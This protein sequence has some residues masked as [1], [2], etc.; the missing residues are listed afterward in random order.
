LCNLQATT[1]LTSDEYPVCTVMVLV[2]GSATLFC[3]LGKY[4]KA[5]RK[6]YMTTLEGV[7]LEQ[8]RWWS[9]AIKLKNATHISFTRIVKLSVAAAI[10]EALALQLHTDYPAASQIA[11]YAGAVTLVLALVVRARGLR[12]ERVEAWVLAAA[13]SK[14]LKSEIYQYRTS[15]G[16]YADYLCR[17]PEATL[18]QRR[19][20]ILDKVKPIAKYIT[21]PGRQEHIPLGLLDAEGYIS[22][23]VDREIKVFRKAEK[24]LAGLQAAWLKGECF[25][26]VLST[27]LAAA[28]SFT[29]RQE[30]AAWVIVI[31][32]LSLASGVTAKGDRYA[33]LLVACRT[34]PDRLT[35]IV[36]RWRGNQGTL[37]QL[38]GQVEALLLAEAQAWVASPD[39]YLKDTTLSAVADSS[40]KIIPHF[41]GSRIG[42]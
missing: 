2:F 7:A 17:D 1:P 24:N 33:S 15:S 37:E 19:D 23:R 31:T 9:T 28:F 41:P 32:T 22:E 30:Y 18:L 26:I 3:K 10:L 6:H 11:G 8:E 39:E 16:A 35:S 12:T 5:R 4:N 36:G 40:P 14:S 34:M 21:E 42:A 27:L 29:H 20:D 25:L 13:A 38:V